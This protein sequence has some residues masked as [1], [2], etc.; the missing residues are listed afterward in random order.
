MLL[1]HVCLLPLVVGLVV[2]WHIL[3]VR[4]HGVVPPMDATESDLQAPETTATPPVAEAVTLDAGGAETA[5]G[6]GAEVPS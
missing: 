4:K 2:G 1:Y 6:S 3:L 5:A